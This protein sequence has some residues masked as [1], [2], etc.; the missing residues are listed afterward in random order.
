MYWDN[1]QIVEDKPMFSGWLFTYFIPNVSD[2]RELYRDQTQ[3]RYRIDR[4]CICTIAPKFMIILYE[5][6]SSFG[7][8]MEKF[9]DIGR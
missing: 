8:N 2:T 9:I 4:N 6:M 7:E 1:L 3:N 5:N